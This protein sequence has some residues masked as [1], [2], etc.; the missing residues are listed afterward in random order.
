MLVNRGHNER[1]VPK[2]ESDAPNWAR[3]SPDKKNECV[4][5]CGASLPT[6][7]DGAR[8][9]MRQQPQTRT[10]GSGSRLQ[11]LADGLEVNDRV[12]G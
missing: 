9:T 12:M 4:D 3:D 6:T 5:R 7:Y 1:I 8:V 10:V 2:G 11:V